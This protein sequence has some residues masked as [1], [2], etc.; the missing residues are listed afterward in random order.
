MTRYVSFTR[1]PDVA[2]GEPIIS[3]Q[4]QAVAAIE[5][6]RRIEWEVKSQYQR[7]RREYLPRFASF[8]PNPNVRC[9]YHIAAD[10]GDS[11]ERDFGVSEP[12][13]ADGNFGGFDVIQSNLECAL[14]EIFNLESSLKGLGAPKKN[15]HHTDIAG[16]MKKSTSVDVGTSMHK[17]MALL[18]GVPESFPQRKRSL[19]NAS[20][21]PHRGSLVNLLSRSRSFFDAGSLAA[22]TKASSIDV[23]FEPMLHRIQSVRRRMGQTNQRY[24]QMLYAHE[25]VHLVT[26]KKHINEKDEKYIIKRRD[27][28]SSSDDL[29]ANSDDV[30]QM[31]LEDRP[32]V[33]DLSKFLNLA[34]AGLYMVRN[35]VG[36]QSFFKRIIFT[37]YSSFLYQMNYNIVAPT[38]GL[39][40]DLLGFDPANAGII[41]GKF[42]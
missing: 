31:V 38:S 22:S 29:R 20:P 37:T 34:S 11:R 4:M 13:P 7:L 14:R 15:I 5:K 17:Q 1:D 18:S 25:M 16:G 23:F 9:L 39:Y 32:T 33:S 6:S 3:L 27:E 35:P 10:A 24:L 19:S 40:A 8:S 21:I 2:F 28:F 41:I 26:D 30:G 42:M 12:D 36:F